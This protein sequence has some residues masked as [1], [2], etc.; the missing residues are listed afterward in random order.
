MNITERRVNCGYT[1]AEL[2]ELLA[3]DRSTVTKWETG[4]SLP[5]AELL[6]KIA[7]ILNCTTDELL[8]IKNTSVLTE[9]AQEGVTHG[10][11]AV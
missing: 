10:T 3:V 2:A 5:R 4:Q 6:P 1:Q 7:Q 8:G 11:V 9:Q